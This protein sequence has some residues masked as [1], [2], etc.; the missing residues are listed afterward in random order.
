MKRLLVTSVALAALIASP[1]LAKSA[2]HRAVDSYAAAQ[3]YAAPNSVSEPSSVMLRTP[4]DVYVGGHYLGADP[5]PQVRQN[6]IQSYES[7][8]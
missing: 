8:N 2:T 4:Y 1:A 6:L 7:G 3:D 5:D